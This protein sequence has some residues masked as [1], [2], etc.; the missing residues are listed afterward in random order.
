M[1]GK[2]SEKVIGEVV[3]SAA[4]AFMSARRSTDHEELRAR[5]RSLYHS[6]TSFLA[7]GLRLV[8]SR[9]RSTFGANILSE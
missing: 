2:A 8:A 3:N 6:L 4:R 1:K 7:R 5:R 9:Q